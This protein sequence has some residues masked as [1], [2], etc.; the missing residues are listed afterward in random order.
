M[1]KQEER[2][3]GYERIECK[4]IMI[5]K[6]ISKEISFLGNYIFLESQQLV[7]HDD[8][9]FPYL[10]ICVTMKLWEEIYTNMKSTT[11][12]KD[13]KSKKFVYLK[14]LRMTQINDNV[15]SD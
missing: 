5:G 2:I 10:E 1:R 4:R 15:N 9:K 12:E 11:G 8:I 3:W 6:G 14:N 7:V 13:L